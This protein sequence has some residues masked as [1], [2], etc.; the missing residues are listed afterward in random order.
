MEIR[1][2]SSTPLSDSDDNVVLVSERPQRADK[3]GIMF[4][5]IIAALCAIIG[6][7]VGLAYMENQCNAYV[8]EVVQKVQGTDNFFMF[9]P[10][11]TYEKGDGIP[12]IETNG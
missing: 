1:N 8:N 7:I 4:V 12:F 5:M 9:K 10:I 11:D 2:P 6:L 3:V